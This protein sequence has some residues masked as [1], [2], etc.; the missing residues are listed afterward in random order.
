M[1]KYSKMRFFSEAII[2]ILAIIAALFFGERGMAVFAL[3]ALTLFIPRHKPDEREVQLYNK[4]GNITAGAAL[5]ACVA[6]YHFS[7]FTVNHLPLGKNWLTFVVA[8][9]MLSHGISGLIV[10]SKK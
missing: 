6:I 1:N 3:Y 7:D 10:F 9:F 2:G 4:I 5:V 8:F